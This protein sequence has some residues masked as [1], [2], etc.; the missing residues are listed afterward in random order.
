MKFKSIS[1][2]YESKFIT[3]Y[4][5]E[6]ITADGNIKNYEMVSRSSKINTYDDLKN[7]PAEA[8]V[9]IIHDETGNKILLNKE[10]RMAVGDFAYNFPAG[11]I[12]P[13]EDYKQAAIRELWE[14]TG[15]KLTRIDDVWPISYSA[16]GIM[17]ERAI[18]VV[19]A[20]EGEFAPST[21]AE[22]EIEAHWYTKE[23]VKKLVK[24]DEHFAARTQAYCWAWS[25]TDGFVK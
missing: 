9:L 8:V 21:S 10:F 3:R 15:L 23:Q 14:E 7:S 2:V 11:L 12:D 5:I 13:G 4:N 24:E 16:V 20:A 1:K 6:Y 19:G 18:V 17:N 25:H 22:E